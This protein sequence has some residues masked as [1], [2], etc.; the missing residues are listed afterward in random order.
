MKLVRLIAIVG[1][2]FA[3]ALGL[4]GM[5]T[6]PPSRTLTVPGGGTI[7]LPGRF[8]VDD[9][10]ASPFH[11]DDLILAHGKRRWSIGGHETIREAVG[12]GHR[13]VHPDREA[14]YL[15]AAHF[16]G[17]AEWREP[18][19]EV[20]SWERI[21][22]PGLNLLTAALPH[23]PSRV[24]IQAWRDDGP[25]WTVAFVRSQPRDETIGL[26]VSVLDSYTT[27]PGEA[28]EP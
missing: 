11:A 3:G 18:A 20:R 9:P 21:D 17:D 12:V 14:F 15:R 2:L 13:S 25:V 22:H 7:S 28:G 5:G 8:V 27:R 1:T 26:L 10:E 19:R 24:V 4:R 16:L 23:D 6:P